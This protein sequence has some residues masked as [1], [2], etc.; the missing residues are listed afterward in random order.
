[1]DPDH[2]RLLVHIESRGAARLAQDLCE[3]QN[4]PDLRGEVSLRGLGSIAEELA[5]SYSHS[6]LTG[7]RTRL[8][9]RLF[10]EIIFLHDLDLC[11]TPERLRGEAGLGTWSSGSGRTEAWD[12]LVQKVA[13]ASSAPSEVLLSDAA[14]TS[15]STLETVPPHSQ[16][17]NPGHDHTEDLELEAYD[18]DPNHN[19]GASSG[20]W[21]WLGKALAREIHVEYHADPE[22]RGQK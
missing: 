3:Q 6:S 8:K 14:I 18:W 4:I 12:R 15:Q 5:R 21:D 17:S 2:K 20:S 19:E 1:M 13:D 11:I 22:C 9:R 7:T 10:A 16:D